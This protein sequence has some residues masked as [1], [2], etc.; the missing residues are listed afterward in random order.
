MLCCCCLIIRRRSLV[1][2]KTKPL[3]TSPQKQWAWCLGGGSCSL[4][5]FWEEQFDSLFGA[6]NLEL[7]QQCLGNKYLQKPPN[8][9]ACL[10]WMY[11]ASTQMQRLNLIHF[12]E[13]PWL[14]PFKRAF[15][16]SFEK[17]QNPFAMHFLKRGTW[18]PKISRAFKVPHQWCPDEIQYSPK[19][20]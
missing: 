8:H 20:I 18:K 17:R 6:F 16:Q 10:H 4:A 13:H 2:C 12:Y 3:M 9:L 15:W 14:F 19:H 5:L 1:S 11:M 7:M